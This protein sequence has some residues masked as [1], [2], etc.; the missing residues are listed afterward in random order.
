MCCDNMF[1]SMNTLHHAYTAELNVIQQNGYEKENLKECL[2]SGF[3]L[4]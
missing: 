3:N 2:I 4:V 1:T